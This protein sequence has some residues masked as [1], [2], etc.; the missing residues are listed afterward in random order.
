MVEGTEYGEQNYYFAFLDDP[1]GKNPHSMFQSW[2]L[3]LQGIVLERTNPPKFDLLYGQALNKRLNTTV[4]FA[5]IKNLTLTQISKELKKRNMTYPELF[6]IPEQDEWLYNGKASIICSS[7]II[8][9]LKAGHVFDGLHIN[10]LSIEV[11][12]VHSAGCLPTQ[13]LSEGEA[14]RLR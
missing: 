4:S 9:M 2:Q 3:L 11:K 10:V 8:A 12:G 13:H 5:F 1:K 6:A 7:M 14:K